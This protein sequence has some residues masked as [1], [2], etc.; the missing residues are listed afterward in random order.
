LGYGQSESL[1]WSIGSAAF[2]HQSLHSHTSDHRWSSPFWIF[3]G[4]GEYPSL[5]FRAVYGCLRIRKRTKCHSA[6]MLQDCLLVKVHFTAISHRLITSWSHHIMN[7]RR[8]FIKRSP[9]ISKPKTPKTGCFA[10][11]IS[12]NRDLVELEALIRA[13]RARQKD[14]SR[15]GRRRCRV[16]PR[17]FDGSYYRLAAGN[18]SCRKEYRSRMMLELNRGV[19]LVEASSGDVHSGGVSQPRN[20]WSRLSKMGRCNGHPALR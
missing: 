6:A 9:Q 10:Q 19:E 13:L 4:A 14:R 17:D 11:R 15:N 16:A 1:G 3:C 2:R 7:G 8:L 12:D 20:D 18:E 5:P